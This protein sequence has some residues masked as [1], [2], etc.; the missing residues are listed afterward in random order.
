MQISHADLKQAGQRDIYAFII[1]K[2]FAEI[3]R[4]DAEV[5]MRLWL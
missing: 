3:V 5:A 2:L 1:K 4:T